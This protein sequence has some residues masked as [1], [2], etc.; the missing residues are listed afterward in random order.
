MEA[1]SMQIPVVKVDEQYRTV[2]EPMWLDRSDIISTASTRLNGKTIP[3]FNTEQEMFMFSSGVDDIPKLFSD[4][5]AYV[6]IDRGAIVKKD[7]IESVDLL[8][9][10]AILKNGKEKDVSLARIEMIKSILNSK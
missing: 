4:D 7:Y 6:Q 3:V 2:S 9:R 5:E 8:N 10:K 1:N